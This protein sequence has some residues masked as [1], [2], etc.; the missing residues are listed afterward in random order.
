MVKFEGWY[1]KETPFTICMVKSWDIF[2]PEK[3]SQQHF[4]LPRAPRPTSAPTGP[5]AGSIVKLDSAWVSTEAREPET[6][7]AFRFGS[8]AC[9]VKRRNRGIF[10]PENQHPRTPCS[11]GNTYLKRWILHC[12]FFHGFAAAWRLGSF[13][14]CFCRMVSPIL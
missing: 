4:L 1:Y 11:I 5:S 2:L 12:F 7:Q 6:N 10:S 9:S 8:A 13:R 3:R 14:G